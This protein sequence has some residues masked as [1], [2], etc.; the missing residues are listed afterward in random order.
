MNEDTLETNI[1]RESER[2]RGLRASFAETEDALLRFDLG[3][4]FDPSAS[5][6]LGAARRSVLPELARDDVSCT[7]E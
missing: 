3:F 7:P 4:A 5:D 6:G 2:S 1:V